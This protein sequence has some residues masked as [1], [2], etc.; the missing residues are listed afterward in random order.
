[1]SIRVSG[2]DIVGVLSP[3]LL[4]VQIDNTGCVVGPEDDIVLGQ[5]IGWI[6]EIERCS[7]AVEEPELLRTFST[8]K[9]S[10]TV[11]VRV[12]PIRTGEV[13]NS[14]GYAIVIEI[15]R[16][17]VV[18]RIVLRVR[19]IEIFGTIVN[20]SAVSIDRLVIGNP[21]IGRTVVYSDERKITSC[22]ILKV[23]IDSIAIWIE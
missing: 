4:K 7:Y 2:W 3:I 23:R 20:A 14:I 15:I 5:I 22:C 1:M 13:L 19:V 6:K 10:T 16:Q 21:D 18:R 8:V 12:S 9:H 17:E 11:S